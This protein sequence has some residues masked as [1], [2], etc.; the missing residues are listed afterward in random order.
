[1]GDGSGSLPGDDELAVR[2]ELDRCPLAIRSEV[3]LDA[4]LG[5]SQL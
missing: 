5:H 3:T 2:A 4:V 1:M